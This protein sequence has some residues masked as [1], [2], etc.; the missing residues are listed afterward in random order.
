MEDTSETIKSQPGVDSQQSDR[1]LQGEMA[2][3]LQVPVETVIPP[4]DQVPQPEGLA[5]LVQQINPDFNP[6]KF[7]QQLTSVT[8]G[9]INP[10]SVRTTA[11]Q[12]R[13]SFFSEFKKRIAR[14]AKQHP[15][16][17]ISEV[18]KAA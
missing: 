18:E 1:Q 4:E 14:L 3:V 5:R 6:E 17:E 8:P 13:V 12:G 10:D 9:A 16:S 15:G 11:N 2:Q 7:K